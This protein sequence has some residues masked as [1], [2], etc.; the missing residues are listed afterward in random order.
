MTLAIISSACLN[1]FT[2][3]PPARGWHIVIGTKT[4]IVATHEMAEFLIEKCAIMRFDLR[5]FRVV[6]MGSGTRSS[7]FE[8][9]LWSDGD[10]AL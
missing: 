6:I 7:R 9:F 3:S 2:D 4:N 1:G 8:F 10:A 5:Q